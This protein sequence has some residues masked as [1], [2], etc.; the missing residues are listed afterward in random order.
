MSLPLRLILG[1]FLSLGV[2]GLAYRRRSLSRSGVLGALLT[3][4]LTL[5]FGG[6]AWGLALIAF[7][8]SSSL[9]TRWHR[10]RK[11]ALEET[12]S[13][14]GQRDLGQT[15][16][17]GG[18][19]AALAVL[20]VLGPHPDW[21]AAFVG[22]L[23]AATADTW[24]TEVGVLSPRPPR[25]ITTGRPVAAGTSG[26]VSRWGTLA[27]AGGATFLGG[28]FYLF[29]LAEWGIGWRGGA[30]DTPPGWI[31]IPLALAGGLAGSLVDSLLGATLQGIYRCPRC[32]RETERRWHCGG[33][34]APIR[35]WPWLTND[36]VNFL[37][38][39]VGAGVAGGLYLV[40]AGLTKP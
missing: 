33:A 31:V 29:A 2:A 34:T 24:A 20:S 22:A 23:A 39:L 30:R 11:A 1:F 3:G 14:G 36:G 16:A 10:K 8:V 35:G 15:L 38:T 4:T 40:V 5:G 28:V 18:L 9:L 17:N 32:G 26:G 27:A 37:A 13:K 25:L 19:G 21:A 7:F 6:W 12:F